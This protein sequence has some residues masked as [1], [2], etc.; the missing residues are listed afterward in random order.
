MNNK[1]SREELVELVEIIM[2]AGE[3]EKTGKTYTEDEVDRMIEIFEENIL[4]PQG[5]DLIFY[6][7]L[8]GL[9]ID[10]SAEEIVDAGLN[11]KVKESN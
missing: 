9:K 1:L 4:S 7:H 8:C 11:Y 2:N 6:P 10:A 3:D 5:S